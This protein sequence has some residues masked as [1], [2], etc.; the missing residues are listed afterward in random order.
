MNTRYS[1]TDAPKKGWLNL[2]LGQNLGD[3]CSRSS[4][5]IS[6]KICHFC[7]RKFYSPQAL[8]GHQNAHKRERDAARRYH[9]LTMPTKFSTNRSLGVQ[10]HSLVH[11]PSRDGETAVAMFADSSGEYGATW[12]HS[13]EGASLMWPGS[14]Y[15]DPQLASQPSD[16]LTLDLSLKL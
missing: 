8:G 16:L 11:K 13:R 15:L 3:S 7:N 12:V 2:S 9:S 5:P 4:R 6:V 10:A 1:D 14:F